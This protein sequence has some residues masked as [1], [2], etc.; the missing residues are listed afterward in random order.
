MIMFQLKTL[1]SESEISISIDI[2]DFQLK[3]AISVAY[4]NI[5]KFHAQKSKIIAK[6]SKG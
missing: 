5:Y 3:K 6:T 2:V 1:A 4:N